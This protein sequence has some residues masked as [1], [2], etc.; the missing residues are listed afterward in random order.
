MTLKE[1]VERAEED[2]SVQAHKKDGFYL[3]SIIAFADDLEN[4]SK[5]TLAYFHP[6]TK[7]VFSV[8]LNGDIEISEKSDPLVKDHYSELDLTKCKSFE[9]LM[10]VVRSKVLEGDFKPIKAVV[11]IRGD[12][13]NAAV[14]TQGMKVVRL[15]VGLSDAKILQ[16]D[17]SN[18]LK[19]A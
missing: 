11:A 5:W 4:V 14:F 6:D 13:L 2:E 3:S 19:T 18:L 8:T 12:T 1:I 16:F 15:D 17:I 9:D 7:K 10:Q